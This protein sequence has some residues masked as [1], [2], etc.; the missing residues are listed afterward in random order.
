MGWR[1]TFIIIDSLVGHLAWLGVFPKVK[2]SGTGG[3]PMVEMLLSVKASKHLASFP[4]P[5]GSEARGWD[6]GLG[7][8]C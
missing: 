7:K 8:G 3:K 6:S 1:A 4:S 5:R 2:Y